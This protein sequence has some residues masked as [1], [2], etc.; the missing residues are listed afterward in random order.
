MYVNSCSKNTTYAYIN[1]AK[2]FYCNEK[3]D[4][5]NIRVC[6]HPDLCDVR[7]LVPLTTGIVRRQI[8]PVSGTTWCSNAQC[9]QAHTSTTPDPSAC[10]I[11]WLCRPVCDNLMWIELLQSITIHSCKAAYTY[12]RDQSHTFSRIKFCI[13]LTSH[14]WTNWLSCN[15]RTFS[16]SPAHSVNRTMYFIF[17]FS[18]DEW[19]GMIPSGC[20]QDLKLKTSTAVKLS[21]H[22]LLKVGK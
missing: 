9:I 17:G 19:Y 7:L 18:T 16:I 10:R 5:T 11:V 13:Y 8:P 2:K 6:K 15:K 4:I 21:W 1:V 3:P 20:R 22:F 12:T 14:D